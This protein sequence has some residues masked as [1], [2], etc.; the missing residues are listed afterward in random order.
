[1]ADLVGLSIV[2]YLA[3]QTAQF[4]SP[5]SVASLDDTVI[6]VRVVLPTVGA[7]VRNPGVPVPS[8]RR[9]AISE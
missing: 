9:V 2:R 3:S 5:S 4:T 7:T 6:L 1:V 8:V